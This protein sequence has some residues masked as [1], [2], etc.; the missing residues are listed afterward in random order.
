V[1]WDYLLKHIIEGKIQ[2]MMQVTGDEEKDVS[3]Y[4]TTLRK[5]EDTRKWKRK[6]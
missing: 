5:I 3:T 2:G 1:R 4:W 6:H